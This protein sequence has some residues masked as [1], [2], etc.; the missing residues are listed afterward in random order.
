MATP[1]LAGVAALWLEKIT[2]ASPAFRISELGGRLVGN[3]TQQG[4]AEGAD[5]ANVG[6]GLARAPQN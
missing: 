2:K 6:A 5:R 1:H 4:I 3:A